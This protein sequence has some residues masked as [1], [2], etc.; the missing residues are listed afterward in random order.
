[1]V[2]Q[3]SPGVRVSEIDNTTVAPAVA[4]STGAFVGNFRW[5]PVTEVVSISNETELVST[6]GA[7]STSNTVDFHT[8][9]Y[10]LK[11]SNNL[12]VVRECTSAAFNANSGGGSSTLVETRTNYDGQTFSF[13]TT[14]LWIAKY[15]GTLGNSLLVSVFAYTGSTNTSDFNSWVYSSNF[16][17]PPTTSTYASNRSGTGDEMHVIIIDEDGDFTGTPGTILEKFAF[18]SQ[19]SDAKNSNG[20]S[21]YYVDVINNNSKYIWFGAKDSTNLPNSNTTASGTDFTTADADGVIQGSLSGGVESASL[22]SSEFA[23]GWDLFNDEETEDADLLICPDLPS[24]SESTIVN[25]ITAIAISRKDCVA[26]ASPQASD[27]SASAI[28]TVADSFTA[29][30]YLVVDSARLQVYDKYNDQNINIPACSSI[31]GLV[32]ATEE[33]FG[34]WWSPAGFRRGQLL[35]VT[36]LFYNPGKTDID[37]LYKAGVNSVVTFPGRGTVLYGDKTHLNRPSAFDRINVRRLFITLQ[38]TIT[39]AAQDA[40]FE[41]NDEFTRAQFLNIVV[42]FLRDVQ[43]RRGIT[44]FLVVCDTTNN[45]AAVI[46]RNEFVGDIYIKPAR[47]INFI[48]LNF[49]ATRT[50]VDFNE[51]AG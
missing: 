15:P 50:G 23:S 20:S 29:S 41:F 39:A 49:I 43:G 37:T 51:I 13:G 10:Y 3:V 30:S 22:G 17:A 34:S 46:D 45:T 5:G 7:P 16:D 18:V 27:L 33:D 47:S 35:G 28:K 44:D 36:K 38:E 14:G 6:F 26:F 25:D 24:G 4:T 2:N 1:M 11:Y 42:P 48:Q 21:N 9:A 8:A 19:A 32:A 31:A 12:K 40:L